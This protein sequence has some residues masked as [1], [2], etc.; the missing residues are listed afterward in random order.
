MANDLYEDFSERLFAHYVGGAWR[1]PLGTHPIAVVTQDGRALGHVIAAQRAD[2]SRLRNNLRGA[3]A[4]ARGRFADLIV[5][6]DASLAQAL[7]AQ[8][9]CV[10][11]AAISQI[12]AGIR[13]DHGAVGHPVCVTDAVGQ[14]PSRFGRQ[15][16]R[17]LCDGLVYC[18]P[19]TD[20]LFATLLARVAA[21]AD[22]PPG[23]FN[24]LHGE[25][26]HSA[27][28]LAGAGVPLL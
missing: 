8:G 23:A 19:R 4:A 1:A 15:L 3:D 6:A 11:A 14:A 21:D 18:P 9:T 13:G 5:Q 24:L 27:A 10:D 25:C 26:A 2:V 22:L 20:V 12:A 16:G 17:A 7:G 28:L